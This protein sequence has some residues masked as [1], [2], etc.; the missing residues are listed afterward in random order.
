MK[1]HSIVFVDNC[2]LELECAENPGVK[3]ITLIESGE[4]FHGVIACNAVTDENGYE[5]CDLVFADGS[6]AEQVAYFGFIF[7]D[8]GEPPCSAS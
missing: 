2:Q 8:E 3:A 5:A 7:L 6:L 4:V 1:A